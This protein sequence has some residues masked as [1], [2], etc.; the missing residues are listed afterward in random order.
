MASQAENKNPVNASTQNTDS[1][2]TRQISSGANASLWILSILLCIVAIFGN[3]YLNK[4]YSDLFNDSVNS[5]LKGLGVVLLVVLAV[6]VALCTNKGRQALCFARESYTEV[7]RV[8]WPDAQ[9]TK[10]VTIMVG[11]IAVVLAAMLWVFDVFAMFIQDCINS[12]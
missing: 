3:Y 12:I 2:L 5:L 8:V 10:Q 7:R 11:V 6:G 4:E 1:F 9:K